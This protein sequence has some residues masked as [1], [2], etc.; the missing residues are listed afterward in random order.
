MVIYTEQWKNT[1][2]MKTT[3]KLGLLKLTGIAIKIAK[4]S[5]YWKNSLLRK[6]IQ[7]YQRKKIQ[8]HQS[9]NAKRYIRL[10]KALCQ[11]IQPMT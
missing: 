5:V 4:R 1:N 3:I 2:F 6:K 10:T 7:G 9:L 11:E 8:G